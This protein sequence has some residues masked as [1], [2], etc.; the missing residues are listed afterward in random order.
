MAR[1]AAD[2]SEKHPHRT[3]QTD[4]NRQQPTTK[5]KNNNTNSKSNKISMKAIKLCKYLVLTA[6]TL[7]L[8]VGLPGC[9]N[10]EGEMGGDMPELTLSTDALNFTLDGGVQTFRVELT[11]AGYWEAAVTGGNTAIDI[12]PASGT[13][14]TDVTVTA[15]AV[16]EPVKSTLKVTL[17]GDIAGQR[18]KLYSRDLTV[19]QT[20]DGSAILPNDGLTPE[21][22]FTVAEVIAEAKN[23]GDTE[24]EKT[25]YF[26]GVISEIGND[27]DGTP[28]IYKSSYG[29]ATFYIKDEGTGTSNAFYCYRILYLGNK[30]WATGNPNIN[31]GDEVIVCGKITNYK[32][33]TPETVQ[34]NAYLYMLNGATTPDGSEQP[35][36]PGVD[37]SNLSGFESQSAFVASTTDS[38]NWTYSIDGYT[39][40]GKKATG[41]KLGKS[42]YNGVFTSKAVG[43]NGDKVLSLYGVA[44][45]GKSATLYVRVNGGGEVEGVSSVALKANSTAAGSGALN[46]TVSDSDYYTFTLK[47]LTE[48]STITL[49]TSENF[50]ASNTEGRAILAR[51]RLTD[52]NEG[53][54]T[55]EGEPEQ[56]ENP[57]M[58][59][60][61]TTPETAFTV[62]QAIAAAKAIGTTASEKNYYVKG[63]VAEVTEIS[64]QFGNATFNIADADN[65]SVVF[66]FYRGFYLNNQ[67]WTENDKVEVGDEVVVCG[68]IVN[69]KGDTP[70]ITQG[71]YVYQHGSNVSDGSGDDTPGELEGDPIVV[72]SNSITFSENE[73]T[74]AQVVYGVQFKD[75]LLILNKGTNS[76]GPTYYTSGTAVR[77]YG[78]NK[79]TF[80]AGEKKITS[81]KLTFGTSDGTNAITADKGTFAT[82]TWSGSES[83][84]ILTIGGTSG[85]RRIASIA[86]TLEGDETTEPEQPEQP[87]VKS[88]SVSEFLAAAV[89]TTQV[90]ELTGTVKNIKDK[91]Y[92]NF[93]LEDE[94][95]TVYVYGLTK[96]YVSSNDKSFNT[97][98][99]AAG[100]KIKINGYRAAYNGTAQVGSAWLIE[101]VEKAPEQP[102]QPV[103]PTQYI[104]FNNFDKTVVTSNTNLTATVDVYKNE[105]GTGVGNVTYSFAGTNSI[106]TSSP[107]DSAGFSG[108]NNLFFGGGEGHVFTIENIK[109]SNEKLQL[110]FAGC[111]VKTN[112]FNVSLS[113]DG[114]TWAD[115]TYTLGDATNNW[116]L[117]TADFTLPAGTTTL[118]VK[119][120]TNVASLYRIDD[121]KLVEGNG[122]QE[123]K[124]EESEQPGQ[125]EQPEQPEGKTYT[126][127][128]DNYGKNGSNSA[129]DK[130]CTMTMDGIDWVLEGNSQIN[131]WRLGGKSLTEIDRALFSQTVITENI[132]KIAVQH[133][134]ANATV[135]SFKVIVSKNADFSEPLF[136]KTYDFTQ[137][138]TTTVER[139][140]DADWSNCYYKFVYN[141]TCGSSN[142]YVQLKEAKLSVK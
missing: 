37:D 3:N 70:Q 118:Y 120:S 123:V 23:I 5:P 138:S 42:E 15:S 78:G 106:R 69:Y 126:A 12:K 57:E 113:A 49:S 86:V 119:F 9:H 82:D 121:V 139:P 28:A 109:V 137:N 31:V 68:Q 21:T 83:S 27:T 7:T 44:W 80:D 58:P 17:Y 66:V 85:N 67:R 2:S 124:F 95:G 100:D 129:Y 90:Y 77:C 24:S 98:G 107:S 116:M 99:V 47:N 71:G 72:D 8:G 30:K 97:L 73:L 16:S 134:T 105:I 122:G 14:S 35:E 29:N 125:P 81:I 59:E 43:V 79:L 41:V 135:H 104:Y 19:S 34:S 114:T 45:N 48:T 75:L 51:I 26:K 133:G 141:V 32:G 87:E 131:P 10:D 103:D 52:T 94:T 89:S 39:M 40:N 55:G 128:W 11:G 25:Y 102:E 130:N 36:Q 92:G 110:T 117:A 56:P 76:N 13:T 84:V 33:N 108:N 101:I 64:T 46:M 74:N 60:G 132:A 88:V 53:P 91:T 18:T 63:V 140:D 142:Q 22:A 50:T 112:D 20:E 62:E 65:T 111:G 61:G 127:S 136:E 54:E 1:Q 96:E 4:N 93:D 6:L 38:S 115:I